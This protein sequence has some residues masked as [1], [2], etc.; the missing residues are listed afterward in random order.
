MKG[1]KRGAVCCAVSVLGL[2]LAGCDIRWLN[3]SIADFQSKEVQGVWISRSSTTTGTF[4]HD[5]QVPVQAANPMFQN[6]LDSSGQQQSL[7][8]TVQPDPANPDHVTVKIGVFAP[9]VSAY[10]KVSTYNAVGES[11]LSA[12]ETT[13]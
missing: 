11:P 12:A 8:V 10:V 6:I 2:A 4:T 5:M 13:L 9:S 1:L 7:V 3:V